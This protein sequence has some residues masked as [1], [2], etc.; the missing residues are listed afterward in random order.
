MKFF[1]TIF[2]IA[3]ASTV[4][5]QDPHF[6]QFFSS[7]MTLNPAFTGKFDGV[8]RAAV[9]YRNQWPTINRAYETGT[10][11]VDFPI[12]AKQIASTDTWGLGFMGYT[13]KSAAG[14]VAFNYFS[15]STA[16]HK[17]LDEDGY[18]QLGAG[19][20]V[21]YSNMLINTSKLTFEDQLTSAGF[22]KPTS[23]IFNNSTLKSNY[24]DVNAGLLYTASTTDRNNY[25][26]GVSL[27]H[28][29]RPKQEFTGINYNL[30]PRATIHAGGYFPVGE[31]TTLHLSGLY[32]TQAGAHEALLGGAMQFV[33]GDPTGDKPTSFYGG[34]W[35][36]FGDALIPYVG[37][38]YGDLRAGVS[39]DINISDLKTASESRGGIE[40]SLIYIMHAPESKGL[41]CPKF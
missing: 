38:E 28:I 16:Y 19:F 11:S 36:R 25:Y 29:N 23:E 24:I 18:K 41:P 22:T 2:F 20:Q 13:D 3:L 7:P 4:I 14:A 39:Y 9:N 32:S 33:A 27:Y 15:V 5:G 21:T 34:G 31:V 26:V 17:G 35:I 37:L 12:M 40:V 1:I 30:Y 10:A 8:M 6:S